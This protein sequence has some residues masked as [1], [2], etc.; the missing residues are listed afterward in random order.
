M[1]FLRLRPRQANKKTTKALKRAH[2]FPLRRFAL[3]A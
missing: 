3:K 1:P 2:N